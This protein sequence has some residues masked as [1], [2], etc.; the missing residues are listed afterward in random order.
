[1]AHYSQ[2]GIRV[3]REG[4][5]F[6]VYDPKIRGVMLGPIVPNLSRGHSDL[7]RLHC[8]SLPCQAA[9]KIQWM[10]SRP[11]LAIM[12]HSGPDKYQYHGSRF[13]V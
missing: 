4:L 3:L 12:V 11:L 8:F 10:K 1:M 7:L 2:Q 6:R 13:L 5:G 9:K